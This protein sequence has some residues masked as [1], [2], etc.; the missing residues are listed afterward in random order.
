MEI[1]DYIVSMLAMMMPYG[2]QALVMNS[3]YIKV[4]TRQSAAVG[5]HSERT[6]QNALRRHSAFQPPEST[7][8]A[9]RRLSRVR[10]LDPSCRLSP[11]SGRH[12][13]PTRT[14]AERKPARMI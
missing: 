8:S 2:T 11:R 1:T 14:Y 7:E 10:H 12:G 13:S 5:N 6:D 3:K 9:N 4:D